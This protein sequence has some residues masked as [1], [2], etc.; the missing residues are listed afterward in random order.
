MLRVDRCVALEGWGPDQ[1]WTSRPRSVG[2]VTFLARNA[3][4]TRALPSYQLTTLWT[5]RHRTVQYAGV[6]SLTSRSSP[7]S[8]LGRP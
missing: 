8:R 2:I 6:M 4:S 1:G 5:C 3:N 7:R